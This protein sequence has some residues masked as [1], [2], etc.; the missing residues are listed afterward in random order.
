MIDT[1]TIILGSVWNFIRELMHRIKATAPQNRGN[2]SKL[3]KIRSMSFCNHLY[4]ARVGCYSKNLFS[5]FFWTGI[6]LSW[7]WLIQSGDR[8]CFHAPHTHPRV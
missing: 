7:W 8:L 1:R 2:Q 4:C 6:C 5:L 3:W